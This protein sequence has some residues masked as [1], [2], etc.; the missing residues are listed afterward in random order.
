[1][2]FE[3]EVNLFARE[4]TIKRFVAAETA[5]AVVQGKISAMISESEIIE[6][7]NSQTT[8]YSKL[9]SA[10]LQVNALQLNFSDL[11]TKY[12]TV[13]GQYT[14]LD[15]KVASYKAGVDELSANLTSV[16]KN[17]QDNYSTTAEMSTAINASAGTLSVQ[18][19]QVETSVKSYTDTKKSE[20]VSEA[21]KATDT[22]LTSAEASAKAYTDAAKA[23]AILSANES[24]SGALESYSTTEAMNT[25]ISVSAGTLSANL[26]KV[27]TSVK[28]Y[29]D[30]KKTEAIDAAGLVS[31]TKKNEAITAAG[32]ASDAKKT[33]AIK[34][35]ADAADAKLKSYST[36]SEMNTAISI[37]AGALSV[38]LSKMETTVKTYAD[39]KKAE[40]ISAADVAAANKLKSY[41]TTSE[42]NT[43]IDAVAGSFSVKISQT[44]TTVKSYTDAAKAE[45][46]SSANAATAESLKDYSTTA[47]VTAATTET[48]KDY[49]TTEA[50]NA[51][52]TDKLK[53]YST[54]T[55]MNAAIT[56]ATNSLSLSVSSSYALKTD[57]TSATGRLT[58]LE[59]WKKAA[60]LKITDSAIVA[61]V[62]S[63]TAYTDALN[64]KV[65]VGTLSSQL[66]LEPGLIE[67]KSN[68]LAITSTYFKL[69][70]DGKIT[71]TSGTFEGRLRT[72]NYGDWG[73]AWLDLYDGVM[74]GG[75]DSSTITGK[76]DLSANYAGD[77]ANPH[78]AL[79][80]K[81]DLHLQADRNILIETDNTVTLSGSSIRVIR[82]GE[83]RNVVTCSSNFNI[84]FNWIDGVGLALYVGT[85]FMGWVTYG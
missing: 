46:V 12:D 65:A 41:S 30:T 80:A 47:E 64:G 79:W 67:L 28:T 39:T 48:L 25:A 34:A 49:S 4:A 62:T 74:D 5:M 69:T 75:K 66:S 36:T 31:E 1:M 19:S 11:T 33:E 24:L 81:R 56:A 7:N 52:T 72:E 84:Q 50:M 60:E 2:R 26:S 43:A 61:T 18:L 51:A 23:A 63:S 82:A 57:L 35:A 13:T 38:D 77:A 44:E 20:A 71:A 70:K 8:M 15:S 45:A 29:A 68:R 83:T 37:S 78:V 14:A 53:S 16:S 21:N 59:A 22:K 40:A 55:A 42:M 58:T 85:T 6:L 17:I 27:E 9:A 54:T 76:L 73:G 10:I 32:L 3:Q